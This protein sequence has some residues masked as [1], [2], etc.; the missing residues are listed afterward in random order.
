[1]KKPGK[2]QDNQKILVLGAYG[3]IGAGIC[4]S[5]LA[6]GFDVSGLGRS[7]ETARRVLPKLN[8]LFHDLSNLGEEADWIPLI[9]KFD[10]VINSAGA[11]QDSA[12]D[13]LA[14]VHTRSISALAKACAGNRIGLIQISAVGAHLDAATHFMR[15]KAQGDEAIRQSGADYWILRPGMVIA[16]SAYGGSLLLRQLA[17]FPV[18]RPVAMADA[19]IQTVSIEDVSAVV[20]MVLAGEIPE[21]S[22][23]DLVE[24]HS[25]SLRD[26]IRM[27]RQWL[28]YSVAS[29]EW[30]LPDSLM[31]P[32]NLVADAL[33]HLGWRSPLRST[34]TQV[35]RLGVLGNPTTL[36][37]FKSNGVRSLADSLASMPA[38]TED[39]LLARAS[40]A[41]PPVVTVLFLFWLVSGL[42]G[43]FRIEEAASVLT[44]V[45]WSSQLAQ[46]SVVL[47]SLVDVFLAF[48]LVNRKTASLACLLMIAVS[49]IYLV[50]ST[51]IVPHLWLDP[52]GPLVKILPA[53]MLAG[54]ARLLLETR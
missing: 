13:D 12:N 42:L 22:E 27:H 6:L 54:L 11:L 4:R 38:R 43:L 28:G 49:A 31:R 3:L 47:W 48:L 9:E 35:L 26:V 8:W 25:N 44:D 46:A 14:S 15:S 23:L 20:L 52:L 32:V 51:L 10:V 33:G 45:G 36:K 19:Q 53:M 21:G 41:M 1:M 5:L 34:A 18:I 17:A 40:L 7:R 16:P 24:D 50:A 2:G 30:H 37:T 29:A 39:R